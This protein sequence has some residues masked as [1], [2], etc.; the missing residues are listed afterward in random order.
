MTI[1]DRR[2]GPTQSRGAPFTGPRRDKPTFQPSAHQRAAL[3]E[4]RD[5]GP[6]YWQH[7]GLWTSDQTRD[8]EHMTITIIACRRQGWLKPVGGYDRF[9]VD[10]STHV[11]T[12][13]GREAIT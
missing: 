9:N 7:G 1:I 11:I 12:P 6:L 2:I 5:G 13:A 3:V 4:A 8:G 10:K